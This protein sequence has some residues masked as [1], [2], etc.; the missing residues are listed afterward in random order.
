MLM[1]FPNTSD[2]DSQSDEGRDTED[3]QKSVSQVSLSWS[4]NS[5]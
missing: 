2:F 4:Q 5:I 3:P 1:F